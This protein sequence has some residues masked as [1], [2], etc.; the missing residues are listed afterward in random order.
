[1]WLPFFLGAGL[2]S[3]ALALGA[4]LVDR[5]DWMDRLDSDA[6]RRM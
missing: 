3:L 6:A 2:A 5:F 4:I 1:M